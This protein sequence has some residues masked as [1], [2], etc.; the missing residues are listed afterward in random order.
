MLQNVIELGIGNQDFSG[1]MQEN[2]ENT[3]NEANNQ[4]TQD[5]KISSQILQK[6]DITQA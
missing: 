2:L 3:P 6:E 4:E 5:T 1:E